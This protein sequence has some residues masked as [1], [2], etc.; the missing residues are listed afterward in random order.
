[1]TNHK[2][3]AIYEVRNLINRNYKD[4]IWVYEQDNISDAKLMQ[5]N[6]IVAIN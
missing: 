6:I 1:L 5:T 2:Q 4:R 3:I